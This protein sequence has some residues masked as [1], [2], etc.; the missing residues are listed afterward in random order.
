MELQ[1]FQEFHNLISASVNLVDPSVVLEMGLDLADI[2]KL[3]ES[4]V[5]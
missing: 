1:F 5:L 3:E 2:G 4:S